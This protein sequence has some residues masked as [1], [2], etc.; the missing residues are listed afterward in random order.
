MESARKCVV[1][2]NSDAIFIDPGSIPWGGGQFLTLQVWNIAWAWKWATLE[3][4]H[5]W[6]KAGDNT[7]RV[8][9][10]N[11]D[12]GAI[13]RKAH[14]YFTGN[15]PTNRKARVLLCGGGG[16]KRNDDL[17]CSQ[18]DEYFI[19]KVHLSG[20]WSFIPGLASSFSNNRN[21]NNRK[22]VCGFFLRK[23]T[24]PAITA[25]NPCVPNHSF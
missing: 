18:N 17:E 16:V 3:A 9:P 2:Y 24:E 21:T 1:K 13:L 12:L 23:T 25:Q 7:K 22:V 14:Q 11:P 5:H 15:C 20:C 19:P 6:D 8:L 4:T 10:Y